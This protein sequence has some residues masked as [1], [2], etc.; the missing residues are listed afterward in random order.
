MN[1]QAAVSSA[2][3]GLS[4]NF[5]AYL[6]VRDQQRLDAAAA[7]WSALT[8][9]E[10][11]LVREAAVLAYVHGTQLGLSHAHSGLGG[12]PQIPGDRDIVV[13]VLIDV[14]MFRDLYPTLARLGASADDDAAADEG[15]D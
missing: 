15:D 12:T 7:K 11:R 3:D 5:A 6:A 1:E 14:E 4:E 13:R 10:Q 2:D 8:A 9:R